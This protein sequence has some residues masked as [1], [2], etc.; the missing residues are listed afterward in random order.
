ME[1]AVTFGAQAKTYLN[2]R[3]SYPDALFNWIKTQASGN[4]LCWDVGTGNGQAATAL[5]RRFDQVHA[6]DIDVAQIKNAQRQVNITYEVSAAHDSGLEAE[7]VDAITVATALHWFDHEKFW[8]E[9]A[10]VAR[11]GAVF[12]AWTYHRIDTDKSVRDILIDPVREIIKNY[13]SDGNRLSW[14]GYHKEELDMP[15]EV[16]D[17]PAFTCEMVWPPKQLAG[18]LQTWSAYKRAADD[19][20][21]DRLNAVLSQA[22]L[23]LGEEDRRL[24]MPLNTLAARI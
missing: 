16:L 15:F 23:V 21:K 7:T 10:R 19:G 9:A 22:L 24:S 6:T 13:W 8:S 11:P 5:A 14:R 17:M 1:N 3:P 2:Y 12:C 4:G 18:L 20:H